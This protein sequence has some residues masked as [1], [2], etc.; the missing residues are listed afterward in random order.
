MEENKPELNALLKIPCR[1]V[2]KN[3]PVSLSDDNIKE[4]F[5][6][7]F[8]EKEIKNDMIV[9]KLEKK[10][11]LKDRNKICLITVDNF[12]TRQ[13]VIDFIGKFELI[14]PKGIKQKLTI[15]DCLLQKQYK[16]EEDS[17]MG[18]IENIEHFQKFKEFF[19]KDK[20]LDFKAE[21]NKCNYI[22][23]IFIL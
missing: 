20:I 17:V 2:I 9:I 15:N 16:E 14:D 22:F 5:K 19:E 3:I 6:K 11:S 1:L 18:T 8:D 4:I 10:Y 23:I 13:K 7:N 12:E 21:E